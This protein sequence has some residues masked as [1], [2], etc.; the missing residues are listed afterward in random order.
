MSEIKATG[1]TAVVELGYEVSGFEPI[2]RP[3]G[4]VRFVPES[5]KVRVTNGAVTT[6]TVAGGKLLADGTASERVWYDNV[7]YWATACEKAPVW[8]YELAERARREAKK[9]GLIP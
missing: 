1:V 9:A 6:V 4:T 2:A 3:L 7:Y 8:V 5:V